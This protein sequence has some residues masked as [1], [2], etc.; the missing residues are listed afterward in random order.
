MTVSD[1]QDAGQEP[2]RANGV[3]ASQKDQAGPEGAP[4]QRVREVTEKAKRAL[5]DTARRGADAARAQAQTAGRKLTEAAQERPMA[6]LST[7]LAVGLLAGFAIGL[8]AGQ[9]SA[10]SRR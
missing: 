1:I 7:A 8:C 6:S 2:A 10:G 3:G 5:Q 9:M 4:P